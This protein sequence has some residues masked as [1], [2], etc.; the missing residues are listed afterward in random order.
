M[1]HV[2]VPWKTVAGAL[3][4][5]RRKLPCLFVVIACSAMLAQTPAAAP[6]AADGSSLH[7][8]HILGLQGVSNNA[9]GKLS[10][11]GDSMK[12]QKNEGSAA[13]VPISSIQD[14]SLGTQDRQ[15][16]GVPATLGKAAVP[17]GGGRAI[18]LFSHKKYD[19]LTLE[20]LDSDG[21][22]HGAIFEIAKGQA[23]AFKTA[24]VA[25]GAH[26]KVA[27]QTAGTPEVKK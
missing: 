24:L 13:Q 3:R 20:Y 17:F 11:D 21:G 27:E 18:G 26:V 14:V 7:A 25:K 22:L 9:G 2:A 4:P 10:I 1:N 6:A 23:E 15:V 16:G 8:T 19:T 5:I 12:F